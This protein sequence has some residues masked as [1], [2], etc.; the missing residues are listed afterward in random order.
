MVTDTA[1]YR[2]PNYHEATDTPETLDYERTAQV[3][4]GVYASFQ[5]NQ[6]AIVLPRSLRRPRSLIAVPDCGR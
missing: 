1:F 3:V 5:N 6:E 2:N 4:T